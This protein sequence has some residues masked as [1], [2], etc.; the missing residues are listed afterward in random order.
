MH[1]Y[2]HRMVTMHT[3]RMCVMPLMIVQMCFFVF[4][5]VVV[6]MIVQLVKW[7]WHIMSGILLPS[8]R[9]KVILWWL[10]HMWG[11]VLVQSNNDNIM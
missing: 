11:N 10:I 1:F 8:C 7:L 9:L 3:D 5:S 6:M 2:L 4:I